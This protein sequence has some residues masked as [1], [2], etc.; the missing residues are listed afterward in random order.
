MDADTHN[1]VY[2]GLPTQG[3]WYAVVHL[4]SDENN[5]QYP[6]RS[7]GYWYSASQKWN[8][9][10]DVY[11]WCGPFLAFRDAAQWSLDHVSSI[12]NQQ[13]ENAMPKE[14]DENMTPI[15]LTARQIDW[16][17]EINADRQAQEMVF[18]IAINSISNRMNE[19]NKENR[20][21]W[22]ELAEIHGL[23]LDLYRYE[24]KK[25][26]NKACIVCLGER[27]DI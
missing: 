16:M 25:V 22:R 15:P 8:R 5:R 3:G 10:P 12:E 9:N 17:D 21:F 1:W 2:E 19:L 23:D 20:R 11:A 4:H 26:D 7:V 18:K 27:E 14:H 13:K 24:A 6:I